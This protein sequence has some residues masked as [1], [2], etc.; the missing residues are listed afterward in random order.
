MIQWIRLFLSFDLTRPLAEYYLR[1]GEITAI[2]ALCDMVEETSDLSD[3][4][5]LAAAIRRS[6][7]GV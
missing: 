7:Q 5:T 2:L 1:T 3:Y 4:H 6:Y